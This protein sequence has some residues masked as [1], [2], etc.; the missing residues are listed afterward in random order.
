MGA[1]QQQVDDLIAASQG[2]GHSL[3]RAALTLVVASLVVSPSARAEG[4][5]ARGVRSTVVVA[6][7]DLPPIPFVLSAMTLRATRAPGAQVPVAL[8]E[9]IEAWT[10][11]QARPAEQADDAIC[12]E[13]VEYRAAAE[14]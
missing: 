8:Q 9:A 14:I 3:R 7:D 12:A 10:R 1:L 5:T 11:C 13:A 4:E 6:R 2:Q